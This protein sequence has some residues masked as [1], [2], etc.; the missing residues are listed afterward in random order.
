MMTS[1]FTTRPLNVTFLYDTYGS[2]VRIIGI[3]RFEFALEVLYGMVHTPPH[4]REERINFQHDRHS[5]SSVTQGGKGMQESS[6]KSV[7][8]SVFNLNNLF[9]FV[10]LFSYKTE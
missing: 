2:V 1:L 4:L 10:C 9:L 6:E 5:F 3:H 7:I 8:Q